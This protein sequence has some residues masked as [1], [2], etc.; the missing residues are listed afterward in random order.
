MC[1]KSVLKDSCSCLVGMNVSSYLL[2]LDISYFS[3]TLT[4]LFHP[5]FFQVET[6]EMVKTVWNNREKYWIVKSHF[7]GFFCHKQ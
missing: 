6:A 7:K 3:L 5:C 2:F 1:G 4:T